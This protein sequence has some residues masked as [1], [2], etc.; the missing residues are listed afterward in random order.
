MKCLIVSH[1]ADLDGVASALLACKYMQSHNYDLITY[2]FADYDNAYDTVVDNIK[3]ND[4]VFI[5]DLSWKPTNINLIDQLSHLKKENIIFV[6]HHKSSKEVFDAWK[7]KATIYFDCSGDK[8]ATDLIWEF[9][10]NDIEAKDKEIQEW[11]KDRCGS[12]YVED[13]MPYYQELVNAAHSRDLWINDNDNGLYL[14]KIITEL[15]A[16]NVFLELTRHM[17]YLNGYFPA[18]WNQAIEKY[19]LRFAKSKE[20]AEKSASITDIDLSDISVKLITCFTNGFVSD[21]GHEFL[22]D[23]DG[24]GWF[25]TF[26]LEN[27]TLS[28]REKEGTFKNTGIGC[29]DIASKFDPN[30][31]GH[32]YAAGAKPHT[33]QYFRTLDQLTIDAVNH[34]KSL[35]K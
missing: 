15:G 20:L 18:E 25:I 9:A 10:K 5:S 35:C 1:I 28:I 8:C 17:K 33:N 3:D 2:K 26:N 24:Y 23:I 4:F 32:V 27:Y 31:G 16:E 11:A 19:D 30:G 13:N 7:D 22:T 6:D 29:N 14:T 34:V 12:Y 21:I